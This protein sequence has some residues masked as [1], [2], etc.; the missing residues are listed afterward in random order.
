MSGTRASRS[1]SAWKR[2]EPSARTDTPRR[3]TH[4]RPEHSQE[5]IVSET[6]QDAPQGTRLVLRSIRELLDER[7]VVPSYQRGYRWTRRQV[8]ELLDDLYSFQRGGDALPKESFYCLQP[9]VV[10][11]R[12]DGRWELIDGQQRL[13]TI[14]LILHFLRDFMNILGV[15]PYDLDYDTREHSA[16]FLE[17]LGTDEAATRKDENID[18][19]HLFHAYQAI[20]EWFEALDRTTWFGF[21][22]NCLLHA[23]ARNVKVI[24]YQLPPE[25]EPI[26]VFI[27]LNIGKIPLTNAELIRAL[28]LKQGGFDSD[29]RAASSP[30]RQR[31]IQIAHEWDSFEKRLQDDR[32]WHFVHQGPAPY[33]ARIEYLFSILLERLGL[34]PDSH[35]DAYATF[36]AYNRHFDERSSDDIEELVRERWREIRYLYQRLDEWFEDTELYH[37]IGFCVA[38][39]QGESSSQLLVSLLRDRAR[40]PRAEFIASIRAR[41]F[42]NLFADRHHAA[43]DLDDAARRQ[44]IREVVGDL[45]YASSGRNRDRIRPILLLFNIATLLQNP[46]STR[47]FPFDRFSRQPWDIEHI[48]SVKSDMPR[49]PDDQ[50]RWLEAVSDYWGASHSDPDDAVTPLLRR[51]AQALASDP[52]PAHT[53]PALYEDILAHFGEDTDQETDNGIENLALLDAKTNRTYKNAVF[54]IKRWHIVAR[55]KD[56]IYVPV[57]TRNVFLKY[58]SKNIDDMMFWKREDGQNYKAALIGALDDFFMGDPTC[59]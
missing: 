57:C 48:R 6:I 24:W 23:E 28:F 41:I 54:P 21:L 9:V 18:F 46:T 58:Y 22:S 49:R 31:A 20:E 50:R 8:V 2:S 51:C 27:R 11:A 33:P 36:I 29:T 16:L 47:R 53:F 40:L 30:S 56:G 10:L 19:F 34:G 52:F 4:T 3:L 13:T 14:A 5:E 43:E 25:Q 55:D 15:S 38:S 42:T 59:A 17:S 35:D 32:F 26:E 37:L 39:S 7:F 45:D 12:D 44:L 1:A